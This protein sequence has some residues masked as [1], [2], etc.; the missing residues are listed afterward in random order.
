[1]EKVSKLKTPHFSSRK[2]TIQPLIQTPA[3]LPNQQMHNFLANSL[4]DEEPPKETQTPKK[5]DSGTA[6][7]LISNKFD[8][9]SP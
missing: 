4:I 6:L 3:L 5:Q 9:R 7:G 8:I 1:M 2:L